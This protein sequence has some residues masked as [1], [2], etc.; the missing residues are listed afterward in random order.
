MPSI[1]GKP[2]IIIPNSRLTLYNDQPENILSAWKAHYDSLACKYTFTD[3][4]LVKIRFHEHVLVT[5]LPRKLQDILPTSFD[6]LRVTMDELLGNEVTSE[7]KEVNVRAMMTTIACRVSNRT[8]IGLPLCRDSR[9]LG[10]MVSFAEDCIRCIIANTFLPALLEPLM[11]IVALPN[12]YHYLQVRRVMK[13]VIEQRLADI[14]E[15]EKQD[16]PSQ[17]DEKQQPSKN[18]NQRKVIPDDYITWHIRTALT[19]NKPWALDISWTV[20]C[21]LALEFA[22]IHTTLITGSNALLDIFSSSSSSSSSSS[23]PTTPKTTIQSHLRTEASKIFPPTQTTSPPQPPTK[24]LLNT[25]LLTDS[26]LRES[27][28]KGNFSSLTTR[29]V[30]SPSGFH[31]PIENFSVPNGATIGICSWNRHHDAE[32][33]PDPEKFDAWRFARP[34]EEFER[35]RG[36]RRMQRELEGEKE[37][38]EEKRREEEEKEEREEWLRLQNLSMTSVGKDNLSFGMGRHSCPGRFF[39]QQ[40]LKL[41]ISYLVMYYEVEELPERPANREMGGTGMP[42]ATA[43]LRVR[44]RRA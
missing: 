7:W 30:I 29:Q 21:L 13:P 6:E 9:L 11:N 34:R 27:M 36:E 3:P 20:R 23:N 19:E 44:R 10:Y 5:N 42:P 25:L 37:G 15:E 4:E 24:P 33:F 17:P 12:W 16:S 22:T 32:V 1:S 26:I 14:L 38:E 41:L 35:R 39:A 8:L 31:D 28:R 40:E 2:Q 18:K 43:T